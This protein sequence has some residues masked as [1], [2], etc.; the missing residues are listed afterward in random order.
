LTA[1][2]DRHLLFGLL[3]L[4]NGLIDQGQ[5]I[6]AFQAWIRDKARSLADQLVARGDL[7][8]DA[9]AGLEAIVALHVRK[10]RDVERS[11]AAVPA[12]RSTRASLAE[13]GEPELEATLARVTRRKDGHATEADDDNEPDSTASLRVGA[14]TSDGQRFR[15]LRPHA[16]GG[17]G[18]VFVALDAE[19]HRKVALNQ[20]AAEGLTAKSS[21]ARSGHRRK[22]LGLCNRHIPCAMADG[23]RSQEAL[24]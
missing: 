12:N 7:D 17:L 14:A 4:Q 8:A 24:E 5:L 23:T 13:L 11:L 6:L 1:T 16:R 2:A 15:L 9:C 10:H 20:Q 22:C 19:L 18:E 3:A 21:G